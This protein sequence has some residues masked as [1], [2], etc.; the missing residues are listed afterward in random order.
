ME[1]DPTTFLMEVINFLILVWILNRVFYRPVRRIIAERQETME[2]IRAEADQ[3]LAEAAALK[4]N[5]EGRLA[6]WDVEKAGMRSQLQSDITLER[7][8]RMASLEGELEEMREKFR[9][10]EERRTMELTR[11]SEEHAISDAARFASRL[12]TRIATPEQGERLVEMFLEDM[13]ALPDDQRQAVTEALGKDGTAVNVVSAHPL[14][15]EASE[16]F[17]ERFREIFPVAQLFNFTDDPSLLAGIRVIA[18]PWNMAANLKD[19][20]A[21]FRGGSNGD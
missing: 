6:S 1:L 20:L 21:F 17:K 3:A 11:L 9:I 7:E 5:Y 13:A 2:K 10:A 18:G 15:P 4:E 16:L 19:E 8:R 14:T 12:L